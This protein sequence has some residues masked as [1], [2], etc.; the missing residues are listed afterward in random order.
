MAKFVV[1][2]LELD[3]IGAIATGA[4]GVASGAAAGV[5]LLVAE[6]L[7]T[8][9]EIGSLK[10]KTDTTNNKL[11][12]LST[13]TTLEISN[14]NATSST[15][16]SA[17]VKARWLGNFC[18]RQPVHRALKRQLTSYILGPPPTLGPARM[19]APSPPDSESRNRVSVGTLVNRLVRVT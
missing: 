15:S 9:G 11:N 3:R 4:A 14:L 12:N 13:N 16:E 7:I 2:D 8:G 19:E 1:H 17:A 6:G 10:S 5:G 18:P